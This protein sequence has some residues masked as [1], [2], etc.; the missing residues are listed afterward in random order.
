[1]PEPLADFEKRL[2]KILYACYLGD[3]E[4]EPGKNKELGFDEIKEII[5]ER[6]REKDGA[7]L[8]YNNFT[9]ADAR[10]IC[11]ELERKGLLITSGGDV[12]YFPGKEKLFKQVTKE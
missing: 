11:K 3:P 10:S 8:T 4:K 6:I 2:L 12:I 5:V 7:R 9:D 1:M